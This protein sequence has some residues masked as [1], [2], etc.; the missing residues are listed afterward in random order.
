M[1]ISVIMPIYNAELYLKRAI[2]S[3]INQSIGF[4]N[5]E[6]ILIDDNSSD[7]SKDIIVDFS[8]KYDNIKSFFLNNNNGFPGRARNVGIK[9]ATSKYI[10]FL[11]SD[12]EYEQ[13]F[14][15]KAYDVMEEYDVDVALV[16]FTILNKN[17]INIDRNYFLRTT[18]DIECEKDGLKLIKLDKLRNIAST[19]LWSKIFKKSIIKE[20][21]ITFVED[22][23][24][25]DSLFLYNY[26]YYADNLILIDYYGYKHYRH[27]GNVSYYSSK[28][29]HEFIMSYY[30][31]LELV[32]EKYGEIDTDYLFKDKVQTTLFD[33][34]F[35]SDQRCL[36]WEL[37]DFEMEINFNSS[38]NHPWSSF[39]NKL[40]LKR[41]FFI[42][43]IIFKFSKWFKIVLDFM[44][45]I[46]K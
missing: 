25:E 19:N 30:A 6:L 2:D 4:E 20:N 12:D 40:V 34:L 26:Y 27:G 13:E 37:Y 41:K 28:V 38:L 9:N 16:N 11:D 7:S 14:C 22:K 5:I 44:R 33:I 46:I 23:L 21:N 15:E 42:V 8:K 36:L 24:N 39:V 35:A 17:S 1:L 31:I 10:M 18:S 3:V 45:K 29:T 43:I 32:K